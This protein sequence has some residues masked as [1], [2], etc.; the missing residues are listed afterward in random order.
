M[1][2]HRPP[3]RRTLPPLDPKSLELLALAYVERF[4]TTRARLVRYLSRKVRER[5]WEE[6]SPPDLDAIAATFVARGY[7][8]EGA[9]AEAR[10]RAMKARSLGPR[11]IRDRLR[12]DGIEAGVAMAEEEA[13]GLALAFARRRRLGPFGPPASDPKVRA[14]QMAAML[15]AGHSPEISRR[16]LRQGSDLMDDVQPFDELP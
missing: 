1:A 12:A 16:V 4:Q 5:G 10:S 2:Q 6:G 8:D 3:R 9:F 14:Q 15:R 13:L 7:I 11:R